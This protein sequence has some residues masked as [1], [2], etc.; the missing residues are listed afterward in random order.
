MYINLSI[1]I[2]IYIFIYIFRNM[3]KTVSD[4]K[5]ENSS[6]MSIVPQSIVIIYPVSEMQNTKLMI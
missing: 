1:S 3:K 4:S 6:S 5:L 2:Y